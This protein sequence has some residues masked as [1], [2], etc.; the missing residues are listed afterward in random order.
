MFEVL[1]ASGAIQAADRSWGSRATSLVLHAAAIAAAVGATR[2]TVRNEV[3][4]QRDTT[5]FWVPAPAPQRAAHST[6]RPGTPAPLFRMPVMVPPVI[7]D[8]ALSPVVT[9]IPDWPMSTDTS[10]GSRPG[11]PGTPGAALPPAAPIDARLAEEPPVLLA[12][13]EPRYP[14]LLRHAGLEGRVVVEVVLDTLGRAEAASLRVATSA[15]PLFDTE[16]SKVVLGS[17]YRPARMGGRPVRVRIMV[18]VTFS[19]RR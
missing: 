8:P 9:A 12:H 10:S 6:P 17:R 19:L 14:G 11:A 15:H 3:E 4:A 13:P 1:V 2:H 18:P 7:P 5:I 16:A